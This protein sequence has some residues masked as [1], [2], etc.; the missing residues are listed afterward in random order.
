MERFFIIKDENL[1]EKCREYE[2]MKK[3]VRDCFCEFSEKHNI[4]STLFVPSA[5]RLIISATEK[6]FERF[7]SQFKKNTDGTFRNNS[8]MAKEWI[9]MCKERGVK[10]PYAP[11]HE[12]SLM[13]GATSSLFENIFRTRM[14]EIDGVVY[15]SYSID[16]D[17]QLTN[18]EA[19]EELK[20]SEFWK[21]VEEHEQMEK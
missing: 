9:A 2:T 8:K 1:A 17:W 7:G 21:I 11:T 15:G 18:T 13:I 20:P 10:T 3:S 19:F 16:R 12:L 4:E 6:D 5:T 14:F